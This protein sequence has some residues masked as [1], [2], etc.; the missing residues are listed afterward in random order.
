MQLRPFGRSPANRS[1]RLPGHA[2]CPEIEMAEPATQTWT[3]FDL[4]VSAK[5]DFRPNEM[6][7]RKRSTHLNVRP[8]REIAAGVLDLKQ[9]YL[10][11]S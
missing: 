1:R 5:A 9:V 10:G 3:N 2:V 8:G 7:F 6:G 4:T 11:Y